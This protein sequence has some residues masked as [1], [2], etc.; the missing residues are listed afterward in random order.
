MVTTVS[1]CNVASR[2]RDGLGVLR[3]GENA[4]FTLILGRLAYEDSMQKEIRY[5][6]IRGFIR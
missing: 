2:L 3:I 4:T 1:P 6:A 5:D